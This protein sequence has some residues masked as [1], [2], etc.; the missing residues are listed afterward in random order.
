MRCGTQQL[1]L[2]MVL[3]LVTGGARGVRVGKEGAR[4]GPEGRRYKA[5][6]FLSDVRAL[7]LGVRVHCTE[8]SMVVRARADLYG[9]GRL[10][11]AGELRLGPETSAGHCGA[12]RRVGG[13]HVIT[14]GLHECGA[15]LRVEGDRLVYSNTL[16]HIPTPNPFGIVR[17]PGV[18]VPLECHYKRT[19][20]VSSNIPSNPVSPALPSP[21]PMPQSKNDDWMFERWLDMTDSDKAVTMVASVLSAPHSAF[22]LF[23]DHC[24]VTL[25]PDTAVTPT[26]D[27][28]NDHRCSGVSRADGHVLTVKLNSVHHFRDNR[29]P[30]SA[31]FLR[32]WMKTAEAVQKQESVNKGCSYLGNSWCSVDGKHKACECCDREQDVL[33]QRWMTT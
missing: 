19:H 29:P 30:G 24:V 20:F 32:C 31:M 25:G 5:A 4:V 8:H 22:K 11:H 23:L 13:E 2:I 12:T 18:A 27:L 9:T 10:V 1:A 3:T 17:S 14:A 28:I 15:Q 7:P 21:M 6:G 33:I 26:C 16:F